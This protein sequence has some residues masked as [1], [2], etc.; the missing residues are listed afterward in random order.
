[1][2]PAG[3]Q[4]GEGGGQEAIAGFLAAGVCELGFSGR[5]GRGQDT[6]KDG[7]VK[8]NTKEAANRACLCMWGR[9]QYRGMGW[10]DQGAWDLEF[11]S[12]CLNALS[13]DSLRE[14]STDLGP[15]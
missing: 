9:T 4:G 14:L 5:P 15:G 7:L 10:E 8:K 2:R 12:I 11:M 6:G 1:M 13:C 3:R